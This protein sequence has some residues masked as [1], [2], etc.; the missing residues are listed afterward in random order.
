ME[1]KIEEKEEKI[2][3]PK[4]EKIKVR[5]KRR[6]KRRKAKE[7]LTVTSITFSEG[8]L[9]SLINLFS[10]IKTD[11]KNLKSVKSKL[12]RVYKKLYLKWLS[13]L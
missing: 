4:I 11:D 6:A 7:S 10:K 9:A 13:E 2:E 5:K 1:E 3:K 8:E 12:K